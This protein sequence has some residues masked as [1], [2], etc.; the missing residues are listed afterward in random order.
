MK[1][2]LDSNVLISACLF[3]DSVP[4]TAYFKSLSEPYSCVVCDYSIDEV[5]RTFNRKFP[6]KLHTMEA[7]LKVLSSAVDITPTP[8]DDEKVAGEK[9]VRDVKDHPI[10][11]AA[12]KAEADILVSGD[13]DF[14]ESGL[15]HPTI[16]SP[17]EFVKL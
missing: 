6:D 17:A 1:C 5:R 15:N 16:M 4:A 3:P 12:V 8:A 13:K 2:L 11:R 7:F 10:L 14:L 9:A